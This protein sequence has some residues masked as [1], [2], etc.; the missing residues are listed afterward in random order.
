MQKISRAADIA[1][2]ES[3]FIDIT[4]KQFLTPFTNV[5]RLPDAKLNDYVAT[6]AGIIRDDLD[7]RKIMY[8]DIYYRGSATLSANTTPAALRITAWAPNANTHYV[9]FA[10]KGYKLSSRVHLP[11]VA[12]VTATETTERQVKQSELPGFALLGKPNAT[13][14]VLTTRTTGEAFIQAGTNRRMFKFTLLNFMCREMENIHDTT[15]PDYMVR[16]DVLRDPFG[17]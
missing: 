11:P 12:S 17:R 7:F 14:G 4:I 8:D 2:R 9:D 16:R 15:Q 10:A 3:A 1:V 13:S 6:G 5:D